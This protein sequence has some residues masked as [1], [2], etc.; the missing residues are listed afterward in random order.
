M[1][2]TAEERKHLVT[3]STVSYRVTVRT[4]SMK[5]GEQGEM[6]VNV[7]GDFQND[8]ALLSYVAG[9]YTTSEVAVVPVAL[10]DIEKIDKRYVMFDGTF[11]K[12]GNILSDTDKTAG[13]MVR[14]LTLT[15]VKV[16]CAD[17]ESRQFKEEK[18]NVIGEYDS[19]QSVVDWINRDGLKK[20]NKVYAVA[21]SEYMDKCSVKIGIDP[22]VFFENAFCL[23]E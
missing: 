5:T 6:T 21:D 1:K 9:R 4:F 19:A 22:A 23:T 16:I 15:T 14:T 11:F 8:L 10:S 13:L 2:I 20:S 3:K 18:V 17:F 7:S 12:S